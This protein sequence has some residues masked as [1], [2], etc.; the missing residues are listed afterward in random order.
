MAGCF[1]LLLS[2]CDHQLKKD[3]DALHAAVNP[4]KAST[5][6]IVRDVKASAADATIQTEALRLTI[7]RATPATFAAQKPVMLLQADTIKATL[8]K[9]ADSTTAAGVST[10]ADA[11]A[12]EAAK[13]I[14]EAATASNPYRAALGWIGLGLILLGIAGIGASFYLGKIAG[15]VGGFLLYVGLAAESICARWDLLLEIVGGFTAVAALAGVAWLIYELVSAKGATKNIVNSIDAAVAAGAVDM[16]KA[17]PILNAVQPAWVKKL[18]DSLQ[19][20][21]TP[22]LPPGAKP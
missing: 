10:A 2:G 14:A 18:V 4:N 12:L 3:L 21:P 8:A 11:A 20:A 16:S 9:V 17:A 5:P 6:E 19:H 7:D 1:F 15:G 22:P 13:R